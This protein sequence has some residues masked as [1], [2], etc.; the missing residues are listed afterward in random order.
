M[1]DVRFGFA[2]VQSSLRKLAIGANDDHM[3]RV[4]TAVGASCHCIAWRFA[5][6]QSGNL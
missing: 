3:A 2:E 6:R 1:L 4:G 5:A